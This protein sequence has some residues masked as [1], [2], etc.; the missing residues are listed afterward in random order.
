[1]IDTFS[2]YNFMKLPDS[3]IVVV[4][5]PGFWK[6]GKITYLLQGKDGKVVGDDRSC[7]VSPEEFAQRFASGSL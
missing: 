4:E 7:H 6:D 5:R 2:P 3:R 1:L